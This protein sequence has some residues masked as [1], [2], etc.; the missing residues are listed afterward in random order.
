LSQ[1]DLSVVLDSLKQ[2][3]RLIE[4]PDSKQREALIVQSYLA[5]ARICQHLGLFKS[6]TR[7]FKQKIREAK[8]AAGYYRVELNVNTLQ[9][10]KLT[11][12]QKSLAKFYQLNDV[13]HVQKEN[14]ALGISANSYLTR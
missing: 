5:L 11:R 4:I 10:I 8:Q 2:N 7:C 3:H 1:K 13:I 12:V 9:P 6:R 14:A